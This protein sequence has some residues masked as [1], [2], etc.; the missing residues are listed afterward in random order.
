MPNS[1]DV[2]KCLFCKDFVFLS[3]TEMKRHKSIFHGNQKEWKLEQRWYGLI[4][5]SK[6]VSKRCNLLLKSGNQV[7]EHKPKEQHIQKRDGAK[8]KK[9]KP[10]DGQSQFR[11]KSMMI[12]M[13]T[14][15]M[16][17]R[18]MMMAMANSNYVSYSNILK[19]IDGNFV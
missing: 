5:E 18:M 19:F 3:E 13:T 17:M 16:V 2:G 10:K 8:K 7:K 4:K 12:Q 11:M 9:G 15:M 1:I 14:I 6:N